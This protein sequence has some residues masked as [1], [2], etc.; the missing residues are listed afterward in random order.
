MKSTE[1]SKENFLDDV[2]F[3]QEIIK[4]YIIEATLI[5]IWG[6]ATLVTIII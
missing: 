5:I 4:T 6:L 3:K 1:I 2:L